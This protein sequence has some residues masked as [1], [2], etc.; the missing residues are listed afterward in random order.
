M[1]GVVLPV[2]RRAGT[3]REPG[4]QNYRSQ[5]AGEKDG[6]GFHGRLGGDG[7][8]GPPRERTRQRASPLPWPQVDL[9]TRRAALVAC[10]ELC[11][12]RNDWYWQRHFHR[13]SVGTRVPV[14]GQHM[15]SV[16]IPTHVPRST[17]PPGQDSPGRSGCCQVRPK[18]Q[19]PAQKAPRSAPQTGRGV[20]LHQ[21][22]QLPQILG[23]L[24]L[25]PLPAPKRR[26][27]QAGLWEGA[28]ERLSLLSTVWNLHWPFTSLPASS[29]LFRALMQTV[30]RAACSPSPAS[31]CLR[32]GSCRM[33]NRGL[34]GEKTT[35]RSL[36]YK[37]ELKTFFMHSRLL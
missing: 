4:V 15:Q 21:E 28:P 7:D 17:C 37:A 23:C 6:T 26:K 10:R 8:P 18:E 20:P 9:R 2:L 35:N 33:G 13:A 22:F 14:T 16:F 5:R 27:T 31:S 12:Q 25:P 24:N 29:Q 34:R 30:C 19:P 11:R 3:D 32:I 36:V 1:E